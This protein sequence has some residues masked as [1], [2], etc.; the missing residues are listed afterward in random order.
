MI[1]LRLKWPFK[2]T[3]QVPPTPP[4]PVL[5]L[6]SLALSNAFLQGFLYALGEGGQQLR[7]ACLTQATEVAL[8]RL[9]GEVER[10]A[11]A[12][13]HLRTRVDLLKKVEEFEQKRST[14][15]GSDQQKYVHYLTALQ[16]ALSDANGLHSNQS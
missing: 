4:C 12:L 14:T 7:Q 15:N 10:R 2:K 1:P 8:R 5:D 6:S 16:W 11:K 3:N 9:D 13:G